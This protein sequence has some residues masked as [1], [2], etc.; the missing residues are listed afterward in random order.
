MT[1]ATLSCYTRSENGAAVLVMEGS[2]DV[3]T[4]PRAEEA[5]EK[6][7]AE[8]GPDVILDLSRLNFIDSKGVGTL[9]TGAKLTR[10]GKGKLYLDRPTEPVRRIL[11][12][13]GLSAL[14]PP[15]PPRGP[16]EV[17]IADS[18][19]SSIPGSESS[20]RRAPRAR[21]A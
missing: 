5:F 19:R 15:R 9:L 2:L 7:H 18:S 16:L 11:Q 13:C 20:A 10:A 21:A 1:D 14:F 12:V 4:S 3:S 6:F 8:H 17:S